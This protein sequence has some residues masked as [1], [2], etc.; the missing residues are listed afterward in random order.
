MTIINKIK[1]IIKNGSP[2]NY[3]QN[4]LWAGGIGTDTPGVDIWDMRET[5]FVYGYWENRN[6]AG[7]DYPPDKE[8][9]I[10]LVNGNL[11]YAPNLYEF[12]EWLVY[13]VSNPE[14]LN[15]ETYDQLF[16]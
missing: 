3:N 11:Q 14:S 15:K 12:M 10:P 16:K 4:G 13:C 1:N 9:I 5:E 7:P 8:V 2:R 6:L